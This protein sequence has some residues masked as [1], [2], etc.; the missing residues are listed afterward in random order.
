MAYMKRHYI[1]KNDEGKK[2][3]ELYG[4]E[5]HYNRKGTNHPTAC[6]VCGKPIEKGESQIQFLAGRVYPGAKPYLHHIHRLC[7]V[8]ELGRMFIEEGDDLEKA[9]SKVIPALVLA[10]LKGA[11]DEER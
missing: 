9:A 4:M 3:A 11:S 8:T 6:S 1:W 5:F 7:F 10:R 2:Q